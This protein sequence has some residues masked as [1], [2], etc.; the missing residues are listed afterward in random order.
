MR[1]DWIE[2]KGIKKTSEDLFLVKENLFAVF[3]GASGMNKYQNAKGHTGGFIAAHIA[4]KVFSKNGNLLDLTLTAN[5]QIREEM[6][7]NNINISKK[8]RFMGYRSC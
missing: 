6:I 4:K 7:K 2:E 8:E 5:K 3:D 1:I